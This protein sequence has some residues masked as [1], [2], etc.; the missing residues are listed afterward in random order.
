MNIIE[1]RDLTI[2][3]PLRNGTITAANHVDFDIP[4]G[5]ITGLVGESGSGKSTMASAILRVVTSPG[6]ITSGSIIY[7]GYDAKDNVKKDI[8]KFNNAELQRFR[9]KEVAMVFQAAQNALNPVVRIDEQIIETVQ[10][11][12]DMSREEILKKASDLLDYV[13]LEPERILKSYP[14]E[15]SGGMKQRVMIAFS[16]LLD[17]KF[18]ILDE[19]TTALDVITQ[20]YIF[21]ILTK[22]H[23][24]RGITMLLQTHDIAV[25]AK[26]A[27]RIGVMYAGEVVEV[28]DIYEV[29]EDPKHPYTIGLI[30]AAPSLIDDLG[31]RTPIKGSPP[32][33][34]N[35]PSGCPFHPRCPFAKPVCKEVKPTTT[36]L[37]EDHIVKCHSYN[38]ERYKKEGLLA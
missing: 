15:L 20:D 28:G 31:K 4:E 23:K 25:V 18:L 35:L 7:N 38:N 16:L 37:G 27:D 8:L 22:I 19:P 13:R 9:W 12:V 2:Q 10:E 11:H 3:F 34:L 26:V 1:I 32:N 36:V 30:H 14:H 6:K 5:K 17:P 21:D 24:E 33:L 29:F